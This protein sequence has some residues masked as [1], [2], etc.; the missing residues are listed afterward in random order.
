MNALKAVDAIKLLSS[1][2]VTVSRQSCGCEQVKRTCYA[3]SSQIRLIRKKMTEIMTREAS[4]CD[5]KELVGKFIPE[6]IGTLPA[7]RLLQ[8]LHLDADAASMQHVR[9]VFVGNSGLGMPCL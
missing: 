4:S 2:L 6:S 3:Q 7:D 8:S 5:L 1:R 9:L